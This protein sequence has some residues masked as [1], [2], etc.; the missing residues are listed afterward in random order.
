MIQKLISTWKETISLLI[1][2]EKLKQYKKMSELV[3][4]FKEQL[5]L[6]PRLMHSNV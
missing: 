4:F 3:T 1:L 6:H 5:Q 2:E